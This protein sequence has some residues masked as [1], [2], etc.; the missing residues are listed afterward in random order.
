MSN[1]RSYY[2]VNWDHSLKLQEY[3]HH[4]FNPENFY[5]KF[6]LL[7]IMSSKVHN[8]ICNILFR[9]NKAKMSF[10]NCKISLNLVERL[11]SF[12]NFS[13]ICGKDN[14]FLLFQPKIYKWIVQ[15]LRGRPISYFLNGRGTSFGVGPPADT[16]R[17][18]FKIRNYYPV[19]YR[20]LKVSWVVKMLWEML[21]VKI[22]R[23]FF[24][25]L[26]IFVLIDLKRLIG[27]YNVIVWCW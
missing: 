1:I 24:F 17:K 19:S 14:I 11:N 27:R 16:F 8:K 15:S 4:F 9:L 2:H 12:M 10:K 13:W 23:I 20:L 25:L 5:S 18:Y 7:A 26:Q 22:A 3:R 21:P 6:P